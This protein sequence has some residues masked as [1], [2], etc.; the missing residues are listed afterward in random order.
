ML[1]GAPETTWPE[2][3]EFSE[4]ETGKDRWSV[5]DTGE[6]STMTGRMCVVVDHRT[7][8]QYLVTASGSCPLLSA[9]GTPL[10]VLEAG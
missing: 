3:A 2:S 7:G 10:R 1:G 5:H 6:W 9:D 4:L 8:V